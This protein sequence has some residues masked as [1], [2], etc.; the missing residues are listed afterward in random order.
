VAG[1]ELVIC[2]RK[3]KPWARIELVATVAVVVRRLRGVVGADDADR[4]GLEL[5]GE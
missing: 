3:P 1:A 4:V 2:A 5:V